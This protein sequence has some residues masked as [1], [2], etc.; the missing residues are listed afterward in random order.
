MRIRKQSEDGDYVFGNN[1]NDFY[2]DVPIG[3]GQNVETRL[4]LFIQEW[5]LNLEEGTP[6]LQGILGKY[7]KTEADVVIQ[8][9]ILSTE[10]VVNIENYES[11]IDT[12][13]RRMTVT[14]TINTTF[15]PTEFEIS[16]YVRY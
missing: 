10:F 1:Q 9:R 15:G 8:D 6:I 14:C 5:F 16:N 11:I 7:S 13:N 12:E 3:V 2:R 4:L